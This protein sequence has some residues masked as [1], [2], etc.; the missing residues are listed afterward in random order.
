MDKSI[1]QMFYDD[2][3]DKQLIITY[4]ETG[5]NLTNAEFQLETMTVIEAIC[6]EQE[7]RFGCCVASSFEITVLDTVESF[8]GKT[9]NV[10][11]RLERALK[12]YDIG[13]YKV[14]SDKPTADRRYRQITAY[15]AMYDILNTDVAAWYKG[16]TFPMTLR[17]FRNSFCAYFG[18]EQEE[19]TLIN[20]D[21]TVEMTIDPGELPGRTV[22][23]AICELNGCFGHITRAGKLRYVILKQMVE[24]L[25]PADDLY[26]SD[27]L[28]PAD[29]IGTTELSRNTYISCEYEDFIVQHI[30]K[31]Q[32]RQEENDI[33]AISGIG[34]NGYVIEDNFLVYGKSA[35]DLQT[36]AD[37]VLSVIAGVWYRPAQIEACGNPCLEVGDGLLLYT[38]QETIYTYILS[39]TLKG[40]Q[41][42][43]DSYTAEGEEYRTGQVNGIMKS[44]IQL[45]GKSNV[46]TRTVEEMRLQ[47]RDIEK[48]LSNDIKITASGL[49]AEITRASKAEENLSNRIRV[50][51]DGLDAEI[52]RAS[53]KEGTLSNDIKITAEVLQAE[54]KR[55][56]DQEGELSTKI[57]AA[58]SGLEVEVNRAK[59]VEQ[60]LSAQVKV[61]AEEIDLR[62]SKGDV[63]AQL[64]VESDQVTIKG[65][66]FALEADN[67]SISADGTITAK[68]AVMNGSF[69]SVGA[70]GSYTEISSGKIEFYN[71]V[72]KKSGYIKGVGDYLT[73][74]ADMLRV[75]GS[76][77]ASRIYATDG[78]TWNSGYVKSISTTTKSLGSRTALTSAT[79][80]VTKDYVKGTI[81]D[82]SL[83]TLTTSVA[84]APSVVDSFVTGVT[85]TGGS[86]VTTS[87][88]VTLM[89]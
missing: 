82:V 57:N 20:D 79:L 68:N 85:S 33:G 49:Q 88:I 27:N 13:K 55:A 40:I 42:L 51:A 65:N 83:T 45:K 59:G 86:L 53:E 81:T 35:A 37:R 21:M 62:V 18:V 77:F 22:I 34:D 3:V 43:R 28:Y 63:S 80:S 26:P 87:G 76:L 61:H 73:I 8:K 47:M 32:I 31:L 78:V 19:I 50:T 67:C 14:Y 89:T 66:R 38:S 44:I 17:Q 10:A 25:Y 4:P 39:R 84:E 5:T 74:D 30:D 60:N 41:A 6:D 46:L 1:R 71:E 52:K 9:M 70:D 7:L 15:D 54:I 16:L 2:S 58:A 75:T 36:I 29:P 72:L 56:S 64:S 69:K 11:I 48:G 24:G 23:E 12:D